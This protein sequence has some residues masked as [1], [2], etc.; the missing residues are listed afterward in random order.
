MCGQ[1][2]RRVR[3]V[4]AATVSNANVAASAVKAPAVPAA[5]TR[6]PPRAGPASRVTKL[7]VCVVADVAAA[8]CSPTIRGTREDHAGPATVCA[9]CTTANPPSRATNGTRWWT[10]T[11]IATVPATETSPVNDVSL[12]ESDRST[13]R[14]AHGPNA[15]NG[16]AATTKTAVTARAP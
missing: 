14:P 12:R 13:R 10:P 5:A 2:R 1:G 15:M 4:R 16:T 8:R 9:H 11:A 6:S 3:M 7:N